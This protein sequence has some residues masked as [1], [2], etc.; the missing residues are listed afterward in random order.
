MLTNEA[1]MHSDDVDPKAGERTYYAKIG[2]EG[3]A[4]AGSKPFSDQRCGRYLAD[5]GAILE[6]IGPPPCM[7]LDLGCGTGWTSRLLA[8]RGHSVTGIDIAPEAIAMARA[9]AEDEEISNVEFMV[10][11]YEMA[12]VDAKYH[13]VLFYDSLHHAEDE[14]AALQVAFTALKPGGAVLAFEPGHGHCREARSRLAVEK[15]GV[16]EKDMPPSK[17]ASVGKAIGFQ[18]AVFLPFPHDLT[19]SLY[20]RDY[21]TIQDRTRLILEKTWGYFRAFCRLASQRRG[22]LTILW[23]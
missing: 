17:I 12:V 7:I 18:R 1:M 4:H 13:Y 23:R 6:M 11:D 14:H 21:C 19:R 5:M 2:S 3:L 20:R 15:F 9:M 8:R 10:S 16:H 22:G